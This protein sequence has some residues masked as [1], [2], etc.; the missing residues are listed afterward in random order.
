MAFVAFSC[1]H[2]NPARLVGVQMTSPGRY[3]NSKRHTVSKFAREVV[4]AAE[5]ALAQ[6][7]EQP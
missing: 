3:N 5:C 1:V 2:T 7:A 6:L 4:N